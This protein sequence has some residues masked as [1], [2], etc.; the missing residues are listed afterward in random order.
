MPPNLLLFQRD[1]V[2]KDLSRSLLIWDCF[3]IAFAFLAY[4]CVQGNRE[5]GKMLT[6]S[7]LQT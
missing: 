4:L 5:R 1:I 2:K 6:W 7:L 3:K